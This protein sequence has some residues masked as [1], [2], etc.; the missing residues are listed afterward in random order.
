M[1]HQLAVLQR[2][3]QVVTTGRR[4]ARPLWTPDSYA[5]LA[6]AAGV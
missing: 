6:D 2:V 4:A 5:L 3:A 1:L